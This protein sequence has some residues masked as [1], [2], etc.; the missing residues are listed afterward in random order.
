[1]KVLCLL[2]QAGVGKDTMADYLCLNKGYVSVA[3]ADPI[4]RCCFQI[5]GFSQ[6]QLWGPSHLR[7]AVDTRLSGRLGYKNREQVTNN[8]WWFGQHFVNEVFS[9]ASPTAKM[10][11]LASFWQH[12]ETILTRET[13]TPRFVLQTL[14]TEWGRGHDP[15]IWLRY[16]YDVVLSGLRSG[17]HTYSPTLGLVNR[18]YL[19]SLIIGV[20]NVVIPDNRFKN[21]VA[22]GKARGA[23]IVRLR[24]AN[25]ESAL[26]GEAKAHYSETEQ[27]EL[28]DTAFDAVLE[29]PEGIREYHRVL[30][31]FTKTLPLESKAA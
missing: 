2:G 13:I 16:A 1:M 28:A 9:T 21:E 20:P 19:D 29:V 10:D 4:K 8:S 23:T 12:V 6:E 22:F 5:F 24:R 3:L 7:N 31:D 30:D 17:K 26:E 14:G 11:A 25:Y 18:A 27:Q 15:D